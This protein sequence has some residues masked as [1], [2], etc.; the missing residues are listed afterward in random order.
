MPRTTRW[1]GENF[2]TLPVVDSTNNY[3]KE[4]AAGLPHGA[5]LTA[6]LQTGGKG[7]LGRQWEAPEDSSLF[8]SF[9]LKN[10]RLEDLTLLPLLCAMAVCRGVT[11]LSGVPCS[12]KWPNDILA[13]AGGEQKKLCGILC[14]SVL[15]RDSNW[16]VCG[17]GVNLTQTEAWFLQHGLEHAASLQMSCDKVFVPEE[18]AWAVLNEMEPLWEEYLAHGIRALLPEYRQLCVTLGKEVQVIFSGETVTGTA[19]DVSETG[20]LLCNIGGR[21]RAVRS[22]EASVRGLYGYQP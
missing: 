6:R 18:T 11:R 10:C 21:V 13:P 4:N 20:E 8:L 14:E 2:I 17:L 12:I 9:L 19:L 1:L 15:G 3:L 16:V 22:G 5:A 7:R